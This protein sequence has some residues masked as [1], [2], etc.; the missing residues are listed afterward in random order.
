MSTID[1]FLFSNSDA[2]YAAFLRPLLPNISPELIIGVRTPVLK[3]YAKQLSSNALAE[4]FIHKL[5]HK[6]FE[7]NQLHAFLIA[8]IK[9]FSQ[10]IQQVEQFLPYI[11]NWATCDQLSPVCFRRH[12]VELLKYID[13]WLL[14]RLFNSLSMTDSNPYIIRFGIGMLLQHFL[15]DD[16]RE[17]QMQAV[18]AI[19]TEHYYVRMMQAWYFATALAKQYQT[20]ICYLSVLEPQTMMKAVQKARESRRVTDAHK[21]ELNAKFGRGKQLIK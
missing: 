5:P 19:Q 4:T 6:Y 8:Q 20:A 12:K 2:Q 13:T 7:Q 14:G 9:D 21:I 10:C 15:D 16:F 1:N 18:A 3:Q 11:N 17:E